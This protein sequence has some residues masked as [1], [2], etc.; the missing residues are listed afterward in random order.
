MLPLP[1]VV[2]HFALH[3]LQVRALSLSSILG[4]PKPI[5]DLGYDM[6]VLRTC[7]NPSENRLK[8]AHVPSLLLM[9]FS[10]FRYKSY[11]I[12]APFPI[13]ISSTLTRRQMFT[14][15]CLHSHRDRLTPPP[16]ACHS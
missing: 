10:K 14:N 7:I 8:F 15:A 1:E 3:H 11:S 9:Q 4:A 13:L 5:T 2:H 6:L 12:K 16:S